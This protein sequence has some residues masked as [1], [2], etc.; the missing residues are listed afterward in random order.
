MNMAETSTWSCTLPKFYTFTHIWTIENFYL[1]Y[2]M[3]EKLES[4]TFFSADRKWRLCINTKYEDDLVMFVF[5]NLPNAKA[6]VTCSILDREETAIAISL[7]TACERAFKFMECGELFDKSKGYLPNNKLS[8]CCKI[9]MLKETKSSCG[10]TNMIKVP[11]CQLAEDMGNLFDSKKFSDVAIVASNGR[12]I[13]AHKSI[14]SARSDVFSAMFKHK[15]VE[16]E[17]NRVVIGDLNHDIVKEML[18]YMY[19]GKSAHLDVFAKDLLVAADK[20][21]LEKLKAMCESSLYSKL[22]VNNAAQTLVLADMHSATQLK[23]QTI[24][25]IKAHASNVKASA[26]WK[27]IVH[28]HANLI[29]ENFP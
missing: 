9:I 13:M 18:K 27:R 15:T 3:C 19:T 1:V 11:E 4:P 29:A 8:I 25:F 20:Y 21:A 7:K 6:V 28:T 16:N 12:E 26:G 17:E 23:T 10:Q 24:E 22:C 2:N 14:L 5:T